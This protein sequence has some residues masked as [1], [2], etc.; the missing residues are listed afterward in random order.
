MINPQHLML[1]NF[2]KRSF[3]D[4]ESA[5]GIN[6]E[7]C[8]VLWIWKHKVKVKTKYGAM[9]I[10]PELLFPIEITDEWQTK[11]NSTFEYFGNYKYVHE[12]QNIT[13]V[14]ELMEKYEKT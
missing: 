7:P 6:Y 5:T 4:P 9:N 11:L 12:L 10:E 1:G 8:E 13:T 2:I 14:M 3:H